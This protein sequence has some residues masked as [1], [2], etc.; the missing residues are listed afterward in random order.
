M[1]EQTELD[2]LKE[3]IQQ[4]L[5]VAFEALAENL[6]AGTPPVPDVREG[7]RTFERG[8]DL[9]R[10]KRDAE[11]RTTTASYFAQDY[12]RRFGLDPRA[13]LTVDMGEYQTLTVRFRE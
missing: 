10:F 6:S 12:I 13:Q 3:S 7:D 1:D 11:L 8:V 9:Q 4:Q 5:V 2:N